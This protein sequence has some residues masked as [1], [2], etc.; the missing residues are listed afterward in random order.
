VQTAG[1]AAAR[2]REKGD[3]AVRRLRSVFGFAPFAGNEITS[4]EPRL[5]SEKV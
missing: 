4:V 3:I 2:F 1:I 5:W